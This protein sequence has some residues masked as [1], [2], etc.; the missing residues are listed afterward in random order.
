MQVKFKQ[1]ISEQPEFL[2][3]ILNFE[4]EILA[5]IQKDCFGK[6]LAE[7]GGIFV[8]FLFMGSWVVV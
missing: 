7:N 4:Y 3:L 8:R 1:K 6:Q 2:D 5:M